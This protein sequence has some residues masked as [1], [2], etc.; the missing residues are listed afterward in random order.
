MDSSPAQSTRSRTKKR[1]SEMAPAAP[2]GTSAASSARGAPSKVRSMPYLPTPTELLLL[3]SYPVLLTFGAVFSLL[4]PETRAAPYDEVMQAHFQDASL[5]PSYFARKDNVFNTL[6]VKR[7]WF[8]ITAAFFAFLFTHPATAKAQH[9]IQGTIRWG[10]VTLWW[11][12]VTQWFFGPAIIDRGF[13]FT[14]GKCEVVE[15]AVEKGTADTAEMFTAVACKAAG[16]KWRGG[17]DISGHVF[18]LVLGSFFLLQEVGW[19]VLRARERAS[20]ERSVVMGDG[21]IKSASAESQHHDSGASSEGG[22]GHGGRFAAVVVGLSW[23]MILMTAIYF[24]TWF[25]K[26]TGLLVALA[27]LYSV[28]VLPRWIPALRGVVF[29]ASLALESPHLRKLMSLRKVM[30]SSTSHLELASVLPGLVEFSF[31]KA[32]NSGALTFFESEV[33]EI[34]IDSLVYQVRFAPALANKPKG[35]PRN[36][37]KPVDPFENPNPDLFIADLSTSHYLVLNKFPV[38]R[39]HFILVTKAFREQTH[40]LEQGDLAATFDCIN[41]YAAN[42][43]ELFAFFNSG[44]ESGASQPH[45]HIQLLPR[46]GMTDGLGEGD[47]KSSWNLLTDSLLLASKRQSLPFPVFV[48]WLSDPDAESLYVKYRSLYARAFAATIGRAPTAEELKGPAAFSYNLAM[49]RDTLVL[50]PRMAEGAPV[51][52]DDGTVIGQLSLNG[53]VLA[54]TALV[55]TRQELEYLSSRPDALRKVL[56]QIGLALPKA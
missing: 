18:L 19:V 50:C 11:I 12:F 17:H 44:K 26:L 3:A 48:D 21:A 34:P 25:E 41:A 20:E 28:Y 54:G 15:S 46:D 40:V 29:R 38:A 23:W 13:R 53:T 36:G 55:R 52:A 27:G 24:H 31:S 37:Q 33:Q 51:V 30:T 49:T 9:K 39:Q 16:G 10:L 5:A 22:L 32:K 7:G 35:P 56:S 1:P 45:R 43:R 14:G 8:W 4:S 42:G 2:N 47:K 6:F